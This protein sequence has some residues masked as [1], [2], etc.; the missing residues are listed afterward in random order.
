MPQFLVAI[1]HP[2]NDDPS[3]EGEAMIRA[4]SARARSGRGTRCTRRGKCHP[5]RRVCA[6][7]LP[8]LSQRSRRSTHE[9]GKV[10]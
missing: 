4:I 1:Q 2:E 3:L 9:D 10:R 6:S 8:S 7:R 5:Y